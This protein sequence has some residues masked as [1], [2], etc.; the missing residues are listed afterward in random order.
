MKLLIPC[1]VLLAPL[2]AWDAGEGLARVV[3]EDSTSFW[4]SHQSSPEPR[5]VAE[6]R[7][8]SLDLSA[9][10]LW[11]ALN[12]RELVAADGQANALRFF[13]GTLRLVRSIG[14]K[15]SA[16]GE[17]Q[18]FAG[19]GIEKGSIWISDAV[20]RRVSFFSPDGALRHVVDLRSGMTRSR[21][22]AGVPFGRSAGKFL[23]AERATTGSWELPPMTPLLALSDDYS[24]CDTVRLVYRGRPVMR[25]GAGGFLAYQ[26][27]DDGTLV[28]A[29][30]DGS[31]LA[32]VDRSTASN[33][34]TQGS[35]EIAVMTAERSQWHRRQFAFTPV[36]ISTKTHDSVRQ[37]ALRLLEEMRLETRG[38]AQVLDREML[39]PQFYPPVSQLLVAGS[40]E[41]WLRREA[42]AS[43]PVY[44]AYTKDLILLGRVTLPRGAKLVAAYGN[45]LW[46]ALEDSSAE[47]RLQRRVAPLVW[48]R[49]RPAT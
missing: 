25:V 16:P 18:L 3:A 40:G 39:R 8:D 4:N 24:S 23:A 43:R 41:I 46:V 2:N 7:S 36:R 26:P 47:V 38:A 27:F 21:C 19:G 31:G 11:L 13:D 22:V 29:F 30:P 5:L 12:E 15:G 48:R 45:T 14:R 9:V 10:R 44:E 20:L 33:E 35:F 28:N 42:A 34:R 32:I 6:F 1:I 49:E 17:F 37:E